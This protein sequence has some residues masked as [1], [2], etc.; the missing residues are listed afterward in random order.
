[1]NNGIT[2]TLY[3]DLTFKNRASCI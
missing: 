2:M 3:V 1:M